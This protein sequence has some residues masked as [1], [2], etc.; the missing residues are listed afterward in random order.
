MPIFDMCSIT[1][2]D[3]GQQNEVLLAFFCHFPLWFSQVAVT[4]QRQTEK[5]TK[6]EHQRVRKES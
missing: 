1:R 5:D 3:Y 4:L 2:I 6:L